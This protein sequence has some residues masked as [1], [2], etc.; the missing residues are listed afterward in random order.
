MCTA[1]ESCEKWHLMWTSTFLWKSWTVLSSSSELFVRA[2]LISDECRSEFSKFL[3]RFSIVSCSIRSW[4]WLSC[5]TS[6]NFWW[7][8]SARTWSSRIKTRVESYIFRRACVFVSNFWNFHSCFCRKSKCSHRL[9]I[10]KISYWFRIYRTSSASRHCK[11]NKKR[12]TARIFEKFLFASRTKR[13]FCDSSSESSYDSEEN[14]SLNRLFTSIFFFFA[15]HESIAHVKSYRML[16]S[17]RDSIKWQFDSCSYLIRCISVS[18]EVSMSTRLIDSYDISCESRIVIDTSSSIMRFV[19]SW[20]TSWSCSWCSKE[21][22]VDTSSKWCNHFFSLSSKWSCWLFW[23]SSNDKTVECM[24]WTK[25][26]A[27]W[28]WWERILWAICW[29]NRQSSKSYR[30]RIAWWS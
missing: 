22:W 3:C 18:W 20:S 24:F 15:D 27:V 4:S 23:T 6:L 7:S 14:W 13:S 5:Q 29:W 19:C 11:T 1:F 28:S 30:R 17:H 10:S 26:W 16:R 25:M 9:R 8:E 12:R 2:N 21:L